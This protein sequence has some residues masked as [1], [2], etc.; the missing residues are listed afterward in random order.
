MKSP[1][2]EKGAFLFL[3]EKRKDAIGI[4]LTPVFGYYSLMITD[5]EKVSLPLERSKCNF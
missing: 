3:L 5:L 1:L 4:H 2:S